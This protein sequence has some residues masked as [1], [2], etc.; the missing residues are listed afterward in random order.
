MAERGG[1]PE[2]PSGSAARAGAPPPRSSTF[3]RLSLLFFLVSL[4]MGVGVVLANATRHY[5]DWP[6][7]SDDM[8]YY[9]VLVRETAE[10]GVVSVDGHR[11]TNGFHPLWFLILRS[12][13]PLVSSS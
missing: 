12:I 9:L 5:A 11:P 6:N 13:Q 1:G 2:E 4:A 7:T 10:H 3:A 8:F